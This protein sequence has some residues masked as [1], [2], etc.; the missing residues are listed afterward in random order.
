MLIHPAR[1]QVGESVETED[2]VLYIKNLPTF[3][4][5]SLDA[6]ITAER[7][8]DG[9][10]RASKQRIKALE[11]RKGGTLG[12]RQAELLIQYLC[13]P[14]LRIPL[15]LGFF[16]DQMRVKALGIIELQDVLDSI[17]FE[18]GRWQAEYEKAMPTE[19]P[20][21]DPDL[22]ATPIGLLFK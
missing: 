9:K 14:Y 8:R 13:A 20:S 2:D 12:A 6:Q 15:V 11:S 3:A 1:G 17:M 18:P 4:D 7:K 16:S 22:A 10:S 21:S 5:K 19:I